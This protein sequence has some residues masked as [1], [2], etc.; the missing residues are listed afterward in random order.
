MSVAGDGA[1]HATQQPAVRPAL[2]ELFLDGPASL[3]SVCVLMCR[4]PPEAQGG[5]LVSDRS[6]ALGGNKVWLNL[7]KQGPNAASPAVS[8]LLS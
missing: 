4:C 8:C 7:G 6:W 3:T 1:G 5:T 2:A